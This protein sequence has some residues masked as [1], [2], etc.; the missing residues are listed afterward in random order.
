MKQI[1]LLTGY[2]GYIGS[3]IY[4]RLKQSK[5]YRVIGINTKSLDITNKEKVMDFFKK[6]KP[7]YIIHT[8]ALLDG[9]EEELRKV[10]VEGTSNIID[11][12]VKYKCKGMVF[13]STLDIYSGSLYGMSKERGE[14][15]LQKS[16]LKHIIL[17]YAGVFSKERQN[18]AIYKFITNAKK[19]MD[20]RYVYGYT[21]FTLLDDVVRANIHS[22]EALKTWI[23]ENIT[24]EIATEPISL[25]DLAWMIKK[26]T[27]SK[28][29][30]IKDPNPFL[31]IHTLKT[32]GFFNTTPLEEALRKVIE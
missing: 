17:R 11:A 2:T 21:R 22:I 6:N 26:I 18:G 28:S 5:F 3:A 32:S 4:A 10:N 27:K 9:T 19:D 15:L 29:M 24:C 12:A 14:K 1:I 30:L 7:D 23:D 13:S 16:P 25:R 31:K 8:A 20:L